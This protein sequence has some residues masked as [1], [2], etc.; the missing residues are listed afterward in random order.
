MLPLQKYEQAEEDAAR[1][2]IAATDQF[3]ENATPVV[4][5]AGILGV[6][7]IASG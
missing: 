2:T 1:D 5:G 7:I 3:L 4:G 6:L